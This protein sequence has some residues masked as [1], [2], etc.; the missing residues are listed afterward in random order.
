MK[1][2]GL[3]GIQAY[4]RNLLWVF[5]LAAENS[6]YLNETQKR[7]VERLIREIVD[8]WTGKGLD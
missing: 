6:H 4:E 8:V 3:D 5:A 1:L 7:T 2:E